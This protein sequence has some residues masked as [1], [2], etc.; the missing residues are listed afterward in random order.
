MRSKY[1][2]DKIEKSIQ[3]TLTSITDN[4]HTNNEKGIIT[5]VK[6]TRKEQ[7]FLYT[8]TLPYVPR[9]E[10]LK[11]KLEKLKGKLYFSYPNKIGSLF[12]KSVKPTSSS[13]IYQIECSCNAI[14]NGETKVEL[15]KQ[16]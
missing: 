12:S 3:D 9:I 1:P 2:K 7:N 11:R 16:N 15:K 10:I 13:I 14:N 4:K 5:N 6:E 8:I